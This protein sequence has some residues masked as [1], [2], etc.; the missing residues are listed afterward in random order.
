MIKKSPILESSRKITHTFQKSRIHKVYRVALT[1]RG[2]I[3]YNEE[4]GEELAK[5]IALYIQKVTF[6]VMLFLNVNEIKHMTKKAVYHQLLKFILSRTRITLELLLHM[7]KVDLTYF[8]VD[9]ASNMVVIS[10]FVAGSTTGFITSWFRFATYIVGPPTIGALLLLRSM[11]QQLL[12]NYEYKK[13][14]KLITDL[15]ENE[16]IREGIQSILAGIHQ[17]QQCM[18]SDCI[19]WKHR[20]EFVLGMENYVQDLIDFEHFEITFSK[21][22]W[23]SMKEYRALR[24][25]LKG[26]K[27]LE[28]D[29]KSDG[30]G[31][32]MTCGFRQFEV[33]ED[34]EC[35]EQEVK[36]I[37]RDAF[38][39]IQHYL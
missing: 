35:T 39:E 13:Y 19:F 25:D 20:K 8:A 2:G 37:V 15:L 34:E 23:K 21:L 18:V 30:F 6:Q 27:T 22:W 7:C 24:Q 3:V 11:Y 5:Q 10:A 12:H 14:E 28:F 17:P 9:E 31:S 4:L 32:L 26:L 1:T 36:D 33:L 16:K 38:Q 29:P